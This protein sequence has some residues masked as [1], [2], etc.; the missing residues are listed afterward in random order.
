M[1]VHGG[2]T[3]V[4][5]FLF[6]H[7]GRLGHGDVVQVLG[8]PEP[9]GS[10]E[11]AVVGVEALHR[12]EWVPRCVGH[13]VERQ[14]TPALH[15]VQDVPRLHHRCQQ[16]EIHNVLQLSTG[17]NSQCVTVVNRQEIHNVLQLSTGRNSQC[18]TAVNRQK[19]RMRYG[20][21][22]TEIHNVLQ[23]S[24]GRN[25]QCVTAVNRQKFRMRYGCNHTEIHNV[26]QWSTGR[27]S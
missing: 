4:H 11:E 5:Q 17:R 7:Q 25:S 16:A 18:V 27:N 14:G 13:A 19:F 12:Q 1:E 10:L 15:K 20:C 2:P 3:H 23:L 26:L 24:T 8:D 6:Q 22:H 21:N 9:D